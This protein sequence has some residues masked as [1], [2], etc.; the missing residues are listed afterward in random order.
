MADVNQQQVIEYIK[1]ARTLT[2]AA[3]G[4]ARSWRFAKVSIAG[5]V[6][7][8]APPGKIALARQAGIDNVT[9]IA[10]DDGRGRNLAVYQV[11][12]SK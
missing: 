1:G 6:V 2:R 10:A 7:F 11:D 12:L 9:Q 4:S 3:N 8:H 5:P